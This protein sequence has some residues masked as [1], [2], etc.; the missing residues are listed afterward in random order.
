MLTELR[1]ALRKIGIRAVLVDDEP[2]GLNVWTDARA[3][4]PETTVW[5]HGS[6][7]T[8]GGYVWGDSYQYGAPTTAG[9]DVVAA[10]IK[11]TLDI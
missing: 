2:E 4:Y 9:A 5:I 11:E 1:K 10:M 8:G 6:P 7:I 3:R